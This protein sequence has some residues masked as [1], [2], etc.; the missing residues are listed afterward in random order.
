MV[1]GKSYIK[2]F[3]VKRKIYSV[4]T[5]ICK[6][7]FF[8]LTSIFPLGKF[9]IN[10]LKTVLGKMSFF[11]YEQKDLPN[12]WCKNELRPRSL[13]RGYFLLKKHV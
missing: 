6:N 7:P 9:L 1:F 10:V 4:S 13:Q 8:K 3:L 2:P 11:F 5:N 12:G